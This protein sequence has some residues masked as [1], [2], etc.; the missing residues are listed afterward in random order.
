MVGGSGFYILD[1]ILVNREHIAFIV[2]ISI[3]HSISSTRHFKGDVAS[4]KIQYLEVLMHF[5]SAA[6]I[7][8]TFSHDVSPCTQRSAGFD[9][10]LTPC[11]HR[12]KAVGTGS[13]AISG[14]A[15]PLLALSTSRFYV[16][17]HIQMHTGGKRELAVF[18]GRFKRCFVGA[19]H[20]DFGRLRGLV[21]HKQRHPFGNGIIAGGSDGIVF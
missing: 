15:L 4:F 21:W 17:E 8:R 6:Y 5:A 12:D 19:L 14:I 1:K 7:Y 11:F 2:R 10:D 16:S 13:G 9:D 3:R 20:D 18:S